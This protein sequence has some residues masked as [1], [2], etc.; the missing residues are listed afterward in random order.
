[1]FSPVVQT[2][3]TYNFNPSGGEIIQTA[4]DRIQVRP[5]E[6]TPTQMQRAVLEMNLALVKFNNQQP[7]L[8]TVDL[9]SV[10]LVQGSATYSVPAETTMILDMF[11]RYGNP[12][13]DRYIQQISR[14]EYAAISTKMAPGFPS[15]FWFDRLISPTITF[16][17]VPDGSFPYTAYYYRVRQIQD[18]TI[19]GGYNIEVIYR[20][21]D[22]LI[23]DL[24]HRL[25]RVY[26]PEAEQQRKMDRDEAW[27]IAATQDVEAVPLYL[28]PGLNGYSGIKG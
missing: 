3:K 26:K 4:F 24:A 21:L 22:A 10:P 13:I 16:Y 7:N 6:I 27:T 23:A 18:A 8:W 19:T 14:T 1:M 11:I 12:P 15:Q 9:Q 20:F 17:L 2:S 25:A 28:Y 5:T